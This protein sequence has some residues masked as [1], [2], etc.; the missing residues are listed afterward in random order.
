VVNIDGKQLR[1]SYDTETEKAAIYMVSA[2]A[3][4]NNMVLG[5]VK[6]DEKSN[7]ITAIPRLLD[8]LDL[9]GALVTIDA[10]GTQREI[11]AQI[12]E[13][14][15][16]YLLALKGNQGETHRQ[17]KDAFEIFEAG[18]K[19]NLDQEID[20]GHGRIE[21]RNCFVVE[22]K[23]WL[24]EEDFLKWKDLKSIIKVDT[25][26]EYRNGKKKGQISQETRYY[27]SSLE[28]DA[29]KINN[30]VRGH[31]GI[32]TKLHW[33]LDVAFNEDQSR[34][35]IGHAPENFALLRHIALNKLK[36]E[37][38]LKRGIK[39]KR[40]KAGWDEEYLIRVLTT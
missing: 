18:K 23:D 34:V 29:Q 17:V 16:D 7:E 11:A 15:A 22:A 35:R 24:L 37:K 9:K 19:G 30:A 25:K 27:I 36:N 31:W 13:A 38:S 8:I 26:F 20:L 12:R 3:N 14:G 1:G 40:K 21:T 6:V 4:A 39:G 10:M 32:E 28:Q 33:V 2:W 5:Q